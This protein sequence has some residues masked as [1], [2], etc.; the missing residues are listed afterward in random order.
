METAAT[1]KTLNYNANQTTI[2]GNKTITTNTDTSSNQA[3]NK[4][5]TNET[6]TET[7]DLS[8]EVE[9]KESKGL[10]ETIGDGL[11]AAGSWALNGIKGIGS[12]LAE[13]AAN[14]AENVES[15]TAQVGDWVDS[16]PITSKIADIAST[17][18]VI[19]TS[20]VS[21]VAKLG[22]YANDGIEWV[23]GK[24]V[25]GGSWIAGQVAGLFS[26]DAKEN[27]DNWRQDFSKDIK[28][29]IARDK[30]GEINKMFYEGTE[31]GRRINAHSA[32]KY[33]SEVAKKIQGVTTTVAEIAAATALTVATGGAA[34]PL[35]FGIVFG[36]GALVGAGKAAE[37]TYQTH[38]TDT[39]FLQELGIAGSGALTGLT[40]VA[41]GKLGQGALEIGKDIVA[42][43][44]A[45][46]LKDMGAQMLNK[47]F[48]LSRLK[49]G[50]SLK[51]AA[52]KVNINAIM[53]YG[54]AAMGTAGSLTPYITG[55]E[56]FDTTAV[57][58]LGGTYLQYLGLNLLEDSARDAISGYKAA[59]S[60]AK[61]LTAAERAELEAI[62]D[63]TS[64]SSTGFRV[65]TDDDLADVPLV[66]KG[67]IDSSTGKPIATGGGTDPFINSTAHQAGKYA[68]L[69][70]PAEIKVRID[71]TGVASIN[72]QRAYAKQLSDL[73]NK[74]GLT[75]EETQQVLDEKLAELIDT[76]EFGRRTGVK[77][78]DK[79][80]DSGDIKNQFQTGTTSGYKGEGLRAQL[81][82]DAMHVP[83][84]SAYADR[85]IYGMLFPSDIDRQS[86]YIRTGPGQG[87]GQSFN[88]CIIMFNKEKV[89]DSTTVSVGDSLDYSPIHMGGCATPSAAS[90]PIFK[91]G[92]FGFADKM[93]S[94]EDFKNAKLEELTG[95]FDDY[96]EV[97]IHGAA[98]H[99]MNPDVINEVVFEKKPPSTIAKKL[100]DAGISWRIA[101]KRRFLDWLR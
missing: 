2:S 18:A 17:G 92:Y 40:W 72:E 25:E 84:D 52:G 43:G 26:K 62:P 30:V 93:A 60:A 89:I 83:L 97:Q 58:K 42:K 82:L 101:K 94:V 91:G 4:S 28:E 9:Q 46:V 67:K 79:C 85:P 75:P 49:D 64:A 96:I 74:W 65:P 63:P 86:A 36:T 68:P 90:A 19:G 48:I 14:L 16:N 38:G 71:E 41:N 54:Q 7:L 76:S 37:S 11:A 77:T 45:T 33:D 78:L 81:E 61:V 35:A 34:A 73:A 13:T 12:N 80:L 1:S 3:I 44:G 55:E 70:T 10:F 21:G 29:D 95:S 87:Y 59:G 53:N 24:V 31:L 57:L 39:T 99:Q 23:G 66:V 56:K 100:E 51:N 20:V 32:I 5:N 50:L 6:K 69:A 15:I 88:R 98:N 22:E 27:I 8:S 47:E